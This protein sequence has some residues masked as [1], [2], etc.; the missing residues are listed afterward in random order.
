MTLHAVKPAGGN[1]QSLQA[2]Y[3]VGFCRVRK[4]GKG[5]ENLKIPGSNV[6]GLTNAQMEQD[7]NQNNSPP[8]IGKRHKR[9]FVATSTI[10]S[11]GLQRSVSSLEGSASDFGSLLFVA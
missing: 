2:I 6:K 9:E 7:V 5:G 8:S 10:V 1:T 3:L 11:T 4:K